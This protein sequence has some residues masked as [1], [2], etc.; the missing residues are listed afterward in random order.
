MLIH[1]S[2]TQKDNTLINV[3]HSSISKKNEE[4]KNPSIKGDFNGLV[5]V[6][7]SD[8]VLSGRDASWLL[9]GLTLDQHPNKKK[10]F[11]KIL[12]KKN[13]IK[14]SAAPFAINKS[15]PTCHP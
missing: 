5:S 9:L 2:S 11:S 7:A 10:T 1:Y 8:H 3:V 13:E 14:N 4:G 15:G 6:S 12:R